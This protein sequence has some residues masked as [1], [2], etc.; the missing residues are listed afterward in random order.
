M[1]IEMDGIEQRKGRPSNIIDS[2]DVGVA[3]G[4]LAGL[5]SGDMGLESSAEAWSGSEAS[6]AGVEEVVEDV[7]DDVAGN[8][9]LACSSREVASSS[10]IKASEKTSSY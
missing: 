5:L 4:G 10:R 7:V 6:L 1:G 8:S 9:T 2:Y 3:E